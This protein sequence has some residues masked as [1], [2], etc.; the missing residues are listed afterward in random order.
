MMMFKIL[1]KARNLL[2]FQSSNCV[3][4]ETEEQNIIMSWCN[5]SSTDGLYHL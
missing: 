1:M 3:P 5:Q 2:K 4:S